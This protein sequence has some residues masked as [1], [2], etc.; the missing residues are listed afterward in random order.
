MNY[1]EEH[2][3]A[4][5]LAS[6]R[7]LDSIA[8]YENNFEKIDKL[9]PVTV[10]NLNAYLEVG[11]VYDSGKVIM[12]KNPF[13]GGYAGWTNIKT[14]RHAKSWVRNTIYNIND[15]VVPIVNNGFYYRC[16]TG[17][18]S[19]PLEPTFPLSLDSNVDDAYGILTWTPSTTYSV[20]RIVKRVSGSSTYYYRCTIS[21]TTGATEPLW[22]EI[23]GS[24]VV[25]GS[26]SWLVC[27][28]AVWKTEGSASEFRPFGKIE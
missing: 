6:D 28:K 27:K 26:V 15:I 21:G 1:T 17:G 18:V 4:K 2:T 14:G 22:N 3:L 9:I 24:T 19:S 13:V 8:E 25:D 23:S 12:N 7:I 11:K 16:I 10:T 5:P 20:G